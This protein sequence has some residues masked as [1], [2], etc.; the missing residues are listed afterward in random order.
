M[1]YG[2]RLQVTDKATCNHY[3]IGNCDCEKCCKLI[4]I[5]RNIFSLHCAWHHQMLTCFVCKGSI[6][7]L[8]HRVY[9]GKIYCEEC[10][11]RAKQLHG[12]EMKTVHK[13][14]Q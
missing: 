13:R 2:K 10:F 3:L 8:D 12:S 9:R 1:N 6:S 11:L 14:R 7:D 5:N 4:T